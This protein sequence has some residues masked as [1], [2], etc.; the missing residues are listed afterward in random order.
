[1]RLTACLP[2]A[3]LLPLPASAGSGGPDS[4]GYT[5]IDTNSGYP[6]PPTYDPP[7]ASEGPMSADGHDTTAIGV[8]FAVYGSL[9]RAHTVQT[10]GGLPFVTPRAH[11]P[12]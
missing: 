11:P 3:L 2:L 9:Y 12:T 1:M 8:D 10:H 6:M 5:W 7:G 4:F